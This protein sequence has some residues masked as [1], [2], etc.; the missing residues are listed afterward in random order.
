MKTNT[1]LTISMKKLEHTEA[2][3]LTLKSSVQIAIYVL[4]TSFL[5]G[6]VIIK[7]RHG[8]TKVS[9]EGSI[10]LGLEV[11]DMNTLGLITENPPTNVTTI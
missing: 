9:K 3:W 7:L 8:Q 10:M 5:K 4:E 1:E 2:T 11:N 6:H